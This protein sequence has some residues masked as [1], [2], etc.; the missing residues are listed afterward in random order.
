MPTWASL[1]ASVTRRRATDQSNIEQVQYSVDQ[2]LKGLLL[3]YLP[4]FIS[5]QAGFLTILGPQASYAG[6]A[7]CRKLQNSK[8]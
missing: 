4:I 5:D 3:G 7:I 2:L 8:T 1:N 6:K